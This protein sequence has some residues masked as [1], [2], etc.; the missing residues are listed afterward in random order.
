MIGWRVVSYLHEY[1]RTI[2]G[3]CTLTLFVCV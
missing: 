2:Y 1:Y 3:R